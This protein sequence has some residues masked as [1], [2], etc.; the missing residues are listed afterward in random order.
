ML[1]AHPPFL[2][3]DYLFF[4]ESSIVKADAQNLHRVSTSHAVIG[5]SRDLGLNYLPQTTSQDHPRLSPP[6]LINVV[7]GRGKF[8]QHTV[9]SR[10]LM[11]NH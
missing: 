8:R 1:E 5:T 11:A 6:C 7:L 10:F 3:L 9:S 4:V 2:P